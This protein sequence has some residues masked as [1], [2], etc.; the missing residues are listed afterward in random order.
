MSGGPASS[1]PAREDR[2]GVALSLA[3]AA[4]CVAVP[5]PAAGIGWLL[6]GSAEAL[7][8]AASL[9]LA[10]GSLCWG[11]RV[12]GRW[13]V[14]LPLWV[15]LAMIV[16]GRLLAH[17][18]YE[19]LLVVTGA[20]LLT[21]SHLLNRHLCRTCATCPDEERE[22]RKGVNDCTVGVGRGVGR[23]QIS[24]KVFHSDNNVD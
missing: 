18:P 1:M 17:E 4:H 11:V 9:V 7:L 8:V 23:A 19:L 5:L 13:G 22:R 12:H 3:C 21:A 16:T 24:I 15:A 14:L 20:M 2:L 6:A 10:A